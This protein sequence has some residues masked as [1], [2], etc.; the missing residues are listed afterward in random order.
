[1]AAGA[2]YRRRRRHRGWRA[3]DWGA[4]AVRRM[5]AGVRARILPSPDSGYGF[6]ARGRNQVRVTRVARC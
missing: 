2:G 6:V 4:V 5:G 3:C 1:V